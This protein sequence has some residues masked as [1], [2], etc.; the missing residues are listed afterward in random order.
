ME[1]HH[2]VSNRPT[3]KVIAHTDWFDVL[4]RCLLYDVDVD[5]NI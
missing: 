3:L 1:A 5:V 2:D 4:Q